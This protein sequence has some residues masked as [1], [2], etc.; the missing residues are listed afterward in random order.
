MPQAP[1][2]RLSAQLIC[3]LATVFAASAGCFSHPAE[4]V[5]EMVCMSN[6][7]CP[8]GYQCL[9]PD[10]KGGCRPIGERAD[11][12]PP[13]TGGTT[14]AEDSGLPDAPGGQSGGG[15]VAG[16]NG[17]AGGGGGQVDV[18]AAGGVGG[19]ADAPAV[20]GSP[21]TGGIAD[22]G[23]TLGS[24]GRG[25][26]TGG[27]SGTSVGT[28][29]LGGSTD[30]HTDGGNG[31]MPGSGGTGEGGGGLGGAAGASTS[32]KGGDPETGGAPGTGGPGQ[33]VPA[34][35]SPATCQAGTCVCENGT[36]YCSGACIDVTSDPK[37]CGGCG[38][39]CPD[40]C[41]AGRCFTTLKTKTIGSP[42]SHIAVN[43]SDIYFTTN[44]DDTLSRMPRGGG[45]ITV[46]ATTQRNPSDVA[47]DG[48]NVYWA[49][50]GDITNNGAIMRMPLKGGS[51]VELVTGE[52]SPI[53]MT[54]DSSD[55][56]WN[57]YAGTI[58]QIPKAGGSKTEV[59]SGDETVE[60]MNLLTDG[61]NLYWT[62]NT[63]GG[64]IF[65]MSLPNGS[66]SLLSTGMTGVFN[67][68]CVTLLAGT[69]YFLQVP[70]GHPAEIA[71]ISTSGHTVT[72][73][74]SP[75][76]G[77]AITADDSGIYVGW[78]DPDKTIIKVSLDGATVTTLAQDSRF[79]GILVDGNDLFWLTAD[80]EIKVTSKLP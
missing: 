53:R 28:G 75:V 9:V 20:G 77:W 76:N 32:G 60:V 22:G 49:N 31:A 74:A 59:V 23:G 4:K 54:I 71:K 19:G 68:N 13:G 5:S 29:G 11:S 47:L 73:V 79:T 41:S 8:T 61:Q 56:Y 46:L 24:G 37:N 63:N 43:A 17:E 65:T 3:L 78:V 70:S 2:A 1:A 57:D 51:P 40:G 42:I 38:K 16:S 45:T 7:Q 25:Q 6:V 72:P 33:C 48:S 69:L 50:Q 55:I 36:A 64:S 18:L 26:Q 66:S 21:G 35:S 52:P 44:S 14:G 30:A 15:G 34:C 67:P 80:G 12:A 39:T 27:L 62:S 10:T 58:Y